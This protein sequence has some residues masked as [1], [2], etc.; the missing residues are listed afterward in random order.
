MDLR[1]DAL[2]S[3]SVSSTEQFKHGNAVALIDDYFRN[4]RFISGDTGVSSRSLAN[5]YRVPV[6]LAVR[7]LHEAARVGV[8]CLKDNLWYRSVSN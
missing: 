7:R 3:G 8:V 6:A 1:N 2:F 5:A 4:P